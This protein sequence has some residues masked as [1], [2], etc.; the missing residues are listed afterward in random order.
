VLLILSPSSGVLGPGLSQACVVHSCV[1]WSAAPTWRARV[2]GI[3]KHNDAAPSSA[4]PKSTATRNGNGNAKPF[5]TP[6]KKHY[7]KAAT[8][9]Q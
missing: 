5:L 2:Q 6:N 4:P 3:L 1:A 9:F 8:F 7:P